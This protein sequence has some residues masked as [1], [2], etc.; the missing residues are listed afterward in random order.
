ML[1]VRRTATAIMGR[2]AHFPVTLPTYPQCP[3]D[4]LPVKS[5]PTLPSE[6]RPS[7]LAHVGWAEPAV[8]P[9]QVT[10]TVLDI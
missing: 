4:Q 6:R 7:Q 2:P 1:I 8:L 3:I 10:R 5:Q 9:V